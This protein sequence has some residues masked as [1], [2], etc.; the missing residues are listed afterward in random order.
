MY[1]SL[2]IILI[3]CL[4]PSLLSQAKHQVG[5]AVSNTGGTGISFN[6]Y[7]GNKFHI[8]VA[9]FPWQSGE[10]PPHKVDKYFNLGLELQR[11]FYIERK[12]RLFFLAGISR[13]WL[14]KKDYYETIDNG[15]PVKNT[16]SQKNDIWNFGIGIGVERYYLDVIS[17]GVKLGFNYQIS[18]KWP[19]DSFA[20]HN[21]EGK[22]WRGLGFGISLHYIIE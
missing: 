20:D 19:G 14:S 2:F 10:E 18:D 11:N 15:L 9:G 22:I 16:T 21:P 13:W 4:S 12:Y 8:Q 1:K 7:L 3:V 6:S 5:L 17:V